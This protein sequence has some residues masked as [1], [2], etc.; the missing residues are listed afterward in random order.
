MAEREKGGRIL[1]AAEA[2]LLRAGY[3]KVAVA[4]VAERAHVGKGTVYLYWP[5]K[6]ELFSAVL[7]R[8][9][10]RQL[11]EHIAALAADPAQSRP[12]LTFASLFRQ[13]A[14]S[15]LA[16]ALY[17]R[18]HDV[19]GELL[20]T[21][22]GGVAFLA[23][24][25]DT[26]ARY[27]DVLHRHGLLADDPTTD[28]TLAY[29]LSSVVAGAFL[30][31]GLPGTTEADVDTR[32]DALATTVRRAFEPTGPPT[33]RAMRAAATELAELY[34]RWRDELARSLP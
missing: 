2:L 3:R 8:D 19:L 33:A 4:E 7:A 23:G 13:V 25:T 18:D 1:D 28:P 12:H 5:S 32:A 24:K 11:D 21:S 20:T 9:S 31:E 6:A 22:Q 17:T 15:P 27:L 34:Q 29:R 30:L 10:V 14:H 16:T 26:T